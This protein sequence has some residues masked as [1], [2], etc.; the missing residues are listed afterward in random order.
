MST[1]TNT[2]SRAIDVRFGTAT[3]EVKLEDG[4]ELIAPLARYPRLR[5][6]SPAARL[7]WR[8]I[9]KGEGLH[10]PDLDVHISVEELG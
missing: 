3:I 10:W 9:G 6:G 1:T 4:R 7:N 2:G 5:D 8:F